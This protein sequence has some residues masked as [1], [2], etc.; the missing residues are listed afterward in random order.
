MQ[1]VQLGLL[2]IREKNDMEHG[3]LVPVWLFTGTFAYAEAQRSEWTSVEEYGSY[4][5]LLII[6]AIDG[7]I[8]DPYLGY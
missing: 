2:R 8:I 4:N 3:L 6:N 7:T 1:D 5:P